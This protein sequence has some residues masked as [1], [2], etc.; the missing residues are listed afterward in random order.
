MKELE[1]KIFDFIN[2]V[3]SK[4]QDKTDKI[5]Q[6]SLILSCLDFFILTSIVLTFVV[7]TFAST[8]IIGMVSS[9]VPMLVV[10]KT[11]ITKGEKIELETSNF[12][13]LIYLLICFISCF[14]SSMLPQSLYGFMKTSIYFAFFFAVCQFLKNN[15]KYILFLLAIIALLVSFESVIGLIQNSMK[16]ENISTWQDTSYVNPEDVLTRVYGTLKPF[17]PNLFGGYLIAGVMSLIGFITIFAN[18]NHYKLTVTS[19]IFSA[20][21]LLTIF[22]TGCRGAYLAFGFII[23][24]IVFF[25]F[26]LIFIEQNNEKHKKMWLTATSSA[27][28]LGAIFLLT[29]HSIL[30]RILSIFI[31]RGDSS[32]SFRM[33]VYNSAFQM[34]HDNWLCGIGVGN[35]VFREIYGL[36]MLSGFDALSTYSVPLEIAVE[37]GIFA[38]I[39]FILFLFILFK[40]AMKKVCSNINFEEKILLFV[41]TTSIGA[42]LIHGLFDTIFFRPQVQFVFWTM[43]AITTVLVKGTAKNNENPRVSSKRVI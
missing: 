31:L 14:T 28:A 40:N 29:H 21:T 38:L 2:F 35:K 23:F 5:R 39:F 18:R 26:R 32:T 41:S 24:A 6:N 3:L 43:V 22:L 37:S 8:E 16:L 42:V 12:F 20:I 1:S 33:N 36:Y 30:Q 7:S 13:L 27:G 9:I 10:F 19:I 11:L 25:S 17:N 34:F 15:K 4:I